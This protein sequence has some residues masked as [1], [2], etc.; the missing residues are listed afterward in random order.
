MRKFGK[1]SILLLGVPAAGALSFAGFA[2]ANTA[3]V[4]S[5]SLGSGGSAVTNSCNLSE[6][7]TTSYEAAN[8][9]SSGSAA[10]YYVTAVTTTPAGGADNG[11]SECA[12]K[13]YKVTLAGSDNSLLAEVTNTFANGTA[14]GKSDPLAT[15]VPAAN[16]DNVYGVVTG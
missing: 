12:G 5:T 8:A 9:V 10:G 7:Y 2:L 3:T 16:V 6:S 15:P 4:S 1:K 14:L 11:G 13:A